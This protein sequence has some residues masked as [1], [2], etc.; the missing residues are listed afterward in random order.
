MICPHCGK[1]IAENSKFCEYCGRPVYEAQPASQKP[2]PKKSAPQPASGSTKS[3]KSLIATLLIIAGLAVGGY[4]V[5]DWM[6]KDQPVDSNNTQEVIY[7]EGYDAVLS[8]RY[9]TYDDLQGKTAWELKVMRNS[10]YAIHGYAFKQGRLYDTF[11][12]Y[13]WYHPDTD[14]AATVYYRMTEIEQHNVSFIKNYEKSHK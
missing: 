4:A 7:R 5:W 9:L 6:Q 12:Q 1:T 10:I 8:E 3:I 13:S 2:T 14:D 11:S